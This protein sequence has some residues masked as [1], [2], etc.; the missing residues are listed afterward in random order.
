MEYQTT[1][2]YVYMCSHL[3]TTGQHCLQAGLSLVMSLNKYLHDCSLLLQ[4]ILLASR[5][6][7]G[8][9]S[10]QLSTRLLLTCARICVLQVITL[11]SRTQLC[12]APQ[13]MST[14]LLFTCAAGRPSR[15]PDSA[16]SCS[17]TNVY[18][19]ALNICSHL[20]AAGHLSCKPDSAWSCSSTCF[21]RRCTPSCDGANTRTT[22]R[23]TST[24]HW[25]AAA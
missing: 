19:I 23:C 12:H 9:A 1:R 11:A 25:I 22:T 13:Q 2:R 24:T 6:Q 8:H 16:W 18:T 3:C 10:Q 17:S 7:V 15:K 20:C 21:E 4:V 5:T 14:R